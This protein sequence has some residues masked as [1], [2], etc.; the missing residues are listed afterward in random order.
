MNSKLSA[1]RKTIAPNHEEDD[2]SDG[3]TEKASRIH[4]QTQFVLANTRGRIALS[5]HRSSL[6]SLY[7]VHTCACTV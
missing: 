3:G 2:D 5:I 6:E 7:Q 1:L 4:K